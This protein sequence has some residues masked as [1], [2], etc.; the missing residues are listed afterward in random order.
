MLKKLYNTYEVKREFEQLYSDIIC[1]DR[2]NL[3]DK[4]KQWELY[5]AECN[6]LTDQYVGDYEQLQ[7]FDEFFKIGDKIQIYYLMSR[8]T[9]KIQKIKV[10][11]SCLTWKTEYILEVVFDDGEIREIDNNI[12]IHLFPIK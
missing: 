1:F 8:P 4:N 9:A 2:H 5:N 3:N 7:R 12:C 6:K 10:E 11:H